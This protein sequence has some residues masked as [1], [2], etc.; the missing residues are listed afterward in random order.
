MS[1]LDRDATI[2]T[3]RLHEYTEVRESS[4]PGA[5]L[6]LFATQ[7]IPKGTVW[8]EATADNCVRVTLKQYEVLKKSHLESSAWSRELL[9]AF[10]MFGYIDGETDELVVAVDDSRFVNHSD[11]PNSMPA[12][13]DPD[14][15]S[16]AALDI[17][18][19]EEILEDYR[20][21]AMGTWDMP[22]EPYL[23]SE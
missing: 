19:G 7:R 3:A 2:D 11:N 18:P 15:Q 12:P 8:W 17:E 5:G 6:G 1:S 21:Y 14:N 9:N 10:Q 22:D 4:V 13:H 16:V 20:S 23:R